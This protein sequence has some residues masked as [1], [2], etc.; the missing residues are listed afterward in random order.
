MCVML[1]FAIDPPSFILLD[2]IRVGPRASLFQYQILGVRG[3]SSFGGI[4]KNSLFVC[5]CVCK[6]EICG[7]RR[8]LGLRWNQALEETLSFRYGFSLHHHL[9]P[10]CS[11]ILVLIRML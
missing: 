1:C 10:W 7:R 5:V 3:K 4:E 8:K 6:L 9:P 2:L 11:R